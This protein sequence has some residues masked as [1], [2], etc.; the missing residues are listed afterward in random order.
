MN[1]PYRRAELGRTALPSPVSTGSGS[2][3]LVSIA[4]IISGIPL[5]VFLLYAELADWKIGGLAD[6]DET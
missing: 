4:L 5:A 2:K 1:S 6:Y 3:G